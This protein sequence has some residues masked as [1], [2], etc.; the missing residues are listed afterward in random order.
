[1]REYQKSGA[2]AL[3]NLHEFQDDFVFEYKYTHKNMLTYCENQD[4]IDVIDYQGNSYHVTDK[5]GC[6]IL[7]NTYTLGKSLDYADLI[8]DKSSKRARYQE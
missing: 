7:P 1:M 8:S 2:I 3:K 4:P 6:C 5:S